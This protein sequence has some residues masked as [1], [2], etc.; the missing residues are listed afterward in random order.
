LKI[1]KLLTNFTPRPEKQSKAELRRRPIKAS[2]LGVGSYVPEKRLTNRDL[3]KMV[4]TTDEWI[5]TRTGIQERRLAGE[6]QAASDLAYEAAKEALH[7]A[8]TESSELDLIIVATVS[9]DMIFPA[10]ACLVQTRLGAKCPAFDL[11]AACAGFPYGLTLAT[12][13]IAS[14][15]YEKILVI[16]A[17]VM[18]AFID[19]KDRS[20][21]VL[22]GDGAGAAVMGPSSGKSA[23]LST[24]LG[25]DGSY[26]DLL[27]IPAGGSRMLTT[28][29]T[30]QQKLHTLKMEGAEVFKLATRYMADAALKAIELAGLKIEDI[31]LFIPHQANLRIIH[32]LAKRLKIPME[33]VFVNVHKYGNMSAA[34]TVVA[35]AEAV[36]EDRIKKGDKILI[37]AFGSGLTWASSVI[38]W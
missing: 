11:Q 33:K 35:L 8:R 37:V 5:R 25:A 10:T 34:S 12:H 38:Q 20:T 36:K 6:G 23:V 27:K 2:I 9:G 18:S 14:G 19:W 17:E 4:D 32:A 21:C 15:L 28:V 29:E 30:V 7:N 26:W 3:E 24:H 16:G 1:D 22:F 31:S 13:L